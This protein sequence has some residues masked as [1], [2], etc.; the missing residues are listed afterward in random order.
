MKYA[1]LVK[2]DIEGK[3]YTISDAEVVGDIPIEEEIY[4]PIISSLNNLTYSQA[5]ITSIEEFFTNILG[6]RGY[7]FAEVSGSPEIKED[8]NEV[9]IIFTVKRVYSL[10]ILSLVSIIVMSPF[11]ELGYVFQ[12]PFGIGFTRYFCIFRA[13]RNV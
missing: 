6:N 3:K 2:S 9:K 5:Q 11:N 8:S 7:A 1:Q 12:A 10:I 13:H 4:N